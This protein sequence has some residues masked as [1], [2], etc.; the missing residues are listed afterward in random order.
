[1]VF[2]GLGKVHYLTLK[3][4]T[5]GRGGYELRRVHSRCCLFELIRKKKCPFSELP[6]PFSSLISA[7]F[8]T[9]GKIG[10]S[11]FEYKKQMIN[12]LSQGFHGIELDISK[13][14]CNNTK[15]KSFSVSFENNPATLTVTSVLFNCVIE[16]EQSRG[17][18]LYDF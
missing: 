1:M 13:A 5:Q 12:E 17:Q 15:T 3:L 14:F 6:D 4:R 8:F 16:T 18:F 11:C 9:Q 2:L 10:V 7:P